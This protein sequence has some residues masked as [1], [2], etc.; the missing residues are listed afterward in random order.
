M[1]NIRG[2][3]SMAIDELA[4]I[5]WPYLCEIQINEDGAG[6]TSDG[7]TNPMLSGNDADNPRSCND[8]DQCGSERRRTRFSFPGTHPPRRHETVR[9]VC[10]PG[11]VQY[12]VREDQ[13]GE[14]SLAVGRDLS[15][16]GGFGPR[17]S[18]PPTKPTYD[19][20]TVVLRSKLS[21]VLAKR[22][23]PPAWITNAGS[24]SGKG[25]TTPLGICGI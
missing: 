12:L 2:H 4:E 9:I 15:R 21:K 20:L 10:T 17:P 1:S 11:G 18:C 7:G 3:E 16:S 25:K 23:F 24:E 5:A 8:K 19:P 14:G 13:R 22:A 6:E